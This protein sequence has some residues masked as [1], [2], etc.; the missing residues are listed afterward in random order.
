MRSARQPKTKTKT[1]DV[2]DALREL[3]ARGESN[4]VI[5]LVAKLIASHDKEMMSLL[6][7]AR[8]QPTKNEGV[9][10]AQLSL[11]VEEL[12]KMAL[13]STADANAALAA[14]APVPP[15]APGPKLGPRQ[16]P[17]RRRP[18]PNLPHVDNE[19]KVPV[20]ERACPQCGTE[21][22]CVGHEITHVIDIEPARAIIR[23]DRRE[24]LACDNCEGEVIVAPLGDKVVDGGAYGSA[25]VADMLVA[26]FADGMP[27][28]RQHE[29]Y[30]RLGLDIPTSSMG[31]QVAWATE[32]LT[33]IAAALFDEVLGSKTMHLDATSLAVLDRDD[34]NGI[35]VGALWGYV[36]VDIRVEDEKAIE[37]RRAAY[38]FMSSGQKVSKKDGE[39]GP[40]DVLELRRRRGMPHVVADADGRFDASFKRPGLVEIGCNMHAR[41]YF[42]KA[43]DA[44][45]TR[46]AMPLAAFKKLYDIEGALKDKPPDEKLAVRGAQSQIVYDALLVWCETH[47]KI[48]RPSSTLGDA[49][50]YLT[51]HHVALMRFLDDGTLPIDNGVVERLHRKPA[52]GRRAYLFAGSDVGGHRAAVAYSVLGTCRLLD[53]NP[54][55]YLSDVLPRL[56]RGIVPARDLPALMPAAWARAR[57]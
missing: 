56:A 53:V 32:L 2:L 52:Q 33:P 39:L 42:T 36:G 41:R 10:G 46:A 37:E 49:L 45:D 28:N 40:E 1:V 34:P 54:L 44:G 11:L 5:E 25:L 26:K 21:R 3:L 14:V 18:L 51:K 16:P 4:A 38:I 57:P 19:I 31:D 7:R 9:S 22:K 8:R 6:E 48:E 15:P 24:K 43:L 47:K 23:D 20:S 27:L 13:D 30:Q 50:R 55:D 17:P 12:K 35:K 29:K